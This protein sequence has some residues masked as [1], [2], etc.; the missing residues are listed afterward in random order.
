MSARSACNL[1][2][3]ATWTTQGCVLQLL[4]AHWATENIVASVSA[5]TDRGKN[6]R[7][8]WREATMSSNVVARSLMIPLVFLL[9]TAATAMAHTDLTCY[10]VVEKY[11]YYLSNNLLASKLGLALFLEGFHSFPRIGRGKNRISQ[12]VRSQHS[13]LFRHALLMLAQ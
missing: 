2:P 13:V 6:A 9:S 7:S 12:L 1:S 11:L 5:S 4:G 8:E 10:G 3:D